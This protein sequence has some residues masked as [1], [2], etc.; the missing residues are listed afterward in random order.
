MADSVVS[1]EIRVGGQLGEMIRSS[2]LNLRANVNPP[3]V[4]GN[5]RGTIPRRPADA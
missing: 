1:Y 4:T 3:S 2:F 5:D